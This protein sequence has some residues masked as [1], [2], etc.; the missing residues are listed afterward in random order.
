MSG[1]VA[2]GRVIVRSSAMDAPTPRKSHPIEREWLESGTVSQPG[3]YD[4]RVAPVQRDKHASCLEF[5]FLE[6]ESPH[7][8]FPE[9]PLEQTLARAIWVSSTLGED[10]GG[11]ENVEILKG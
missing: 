9:S 1:A 11:D 7:V 8:S 4:I 6:S 10:S 2:R 5:V 3:R